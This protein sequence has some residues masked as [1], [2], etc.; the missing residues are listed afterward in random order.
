MILI[1]SNGLVMLLRIE[2]SA[3]AAISY[4]D[5]GCGTVN[6]PRHLRTRVRT[7][8]TV[9]DDQSER[10]SAPMI[11][12]SGSSLVTFHPI[13]FFATIQYISTEYNL[14]EILEDD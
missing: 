4:V 3:E 2:M 5:Q 7:H 13:L 6:V 8:P 11:I 14:P 1:E 12:L 10:F 9:H